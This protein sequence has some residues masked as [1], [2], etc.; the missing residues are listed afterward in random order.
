MIAVTVNPT[1][2]L[3]LV[4]QNLGMGGGAVEVEEGTPSGGWAAAYRKQSWTVDERKQTFAA[5]DRD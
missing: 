3:P 2:Y 1:A 5:K 4:Q